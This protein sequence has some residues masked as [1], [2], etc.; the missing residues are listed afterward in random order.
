MTCTRTE[1]RSYD[2]R[3]YMIRNLVDSKFHPFATSRS[4]ERE[5]LMESLK[6][7]WGYENAVVYLD[8][9]YAL[10]MEGGDSLHYGEEQQNRLAENDSF[11]EHASGRQNPY[12]YKRLKLY[13]STLDCVV[14]LDRSAI[15]AEIK[16]IRLCLRNSG[17]VCTAAGIHYL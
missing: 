11:I 16:T 1:L 17:G 2:G 6:S 15:Y 8:G 12:V 14:E 3:L 9:T 7:V 4:I 10:S 5:S 13:H